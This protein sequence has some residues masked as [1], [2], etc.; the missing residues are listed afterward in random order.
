M[1]DSFM[2]V[3]CRSKCSPGLR[4]H[5]FALSGAVCI[6]PEANVRIINERKRDGF[7]VVLCSEL[8]QARKILICPPAYKQYTLENLY[9]LNL[10][11]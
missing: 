8:S 6:T 10:N 1:R 7:I 11:Y 3:S 2:M 9:M 5:W 4:E